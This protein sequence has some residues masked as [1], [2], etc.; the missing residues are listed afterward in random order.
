MLRQAALSALTVGWK[1]RKFADGGSGRS[2]K[3]GASG[4]SAA[5]IF[6]CMSAKIAA[7]AGW[8][9]YCSYQLSSSALE[10]R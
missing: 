2:E 10:L 7:A 9:L 1:E 4:S 3:C 6:F 8:L 5:G